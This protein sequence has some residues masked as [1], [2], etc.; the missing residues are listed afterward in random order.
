MTKSIITS[1]LIDNYLYTLTIKHV[2]LSKILFFRAYTDI[3]TKMLVR[4]P[5]KSIVTL[6][7]MYCKVV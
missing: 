2:T 4:Y 1:K 6:I 3:K 5:Y 7:K